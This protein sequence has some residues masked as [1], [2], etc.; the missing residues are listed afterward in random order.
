VVV[1]VPLR[2]SCAPERFAA[3]VALLGCVA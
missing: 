2:D 1:T 3:H